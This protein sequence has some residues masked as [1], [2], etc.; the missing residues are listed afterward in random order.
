MYLQTPVS[1]EKNGP[2][3]MMIPSTACSTEKNTEAVTNA[4]PQ[5][6]SNKGGF[7]GQ[8]YVNDTKTSGAGLS[9]DDIL[10]LEKL[11]NTRPQLRLRNDAVELIRNGVD[12]WRN[13]NLR[14]DFSES[15]QFGRQPGKKSL[16]T[17]SGVEGM[18]DE[19]MVRV[20]LTYSNQ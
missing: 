10:R 17:N 6:L 4:A 2:S 20:K 14:G 1:N 19:R 12:K 16:E 18:Q 15:S 7:L 3:Q 8:C 5:D 11:S 9:K 13:G